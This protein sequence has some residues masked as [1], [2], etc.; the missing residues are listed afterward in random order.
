MIRAKDVDEDGPLLS[1]GVAQEAKDEAVELVSKSRGKSLGQDR[2]ELL[3]SLYDN[4]LLLEGSMLGNYRAGGHSCHEEL[5]G[6]SFHFHGNCHSNC[7]GN[8]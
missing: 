4:Q 6:G 3:C 2:K 7:S 5:Q 8:Y 1:E